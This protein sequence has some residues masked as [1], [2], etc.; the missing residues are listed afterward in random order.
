MNHAVLSDQTIARGG[1]Q[2]LL[3]RVPVGDLTL[4][5]GNLVACDPFVGDGALPFSQRV[6]G[7]RYPVYLSVA[8]LPGGDE[9]VAFAT[10]ALRDGVPTRWEPA[11][12]AGQDRSAL[13]EDEF[14][15][16]GVDSGTGCFMDQST[17]QRFEQLTADWSYV[18]TLL[19]RMQETY[20]DTWSYM[21]TEIDPSTGGNLIAFSSGWGDGHY[22][23]YIGSDDEGPVCIVTDFG[24]LDEAQG[25]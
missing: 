1:D 2:I 12:T 13:K 11:V 14:Y 22:A 15:G 21:E 25:E 16:Y 9:R 24:V 10:L 19:E 20:V 23:T 17:A 3:K 5:T 6:P 4:P 8:H 18:E 7:G